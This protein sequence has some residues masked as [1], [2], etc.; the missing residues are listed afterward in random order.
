MSRFVPAGTDADAPD[1]AW[2]KAQQQ[3]ESLRRPKKVDGGTQEGGKS[4]YE[5]LQSNKAAKQEAFEESIRL[6]NQFR[7]LDDDEVEFLDSVLESSRAKENAVK[8]ETA[9]QLEVFRKQRAAAEQALMGGNEAGTPG[10]PAD[11]ESWA[12]KKKKRRRE[13]DNE[14]EVDS[15]LRKVSTT[16]D[17]TTPADADEDQQDAAAEGASPVNKLGIDDEVEPSKAAARPQPAVGLS[18]V[19]YSSDEDE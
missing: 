19:A 18:L 9:E 2:V 12:V 8:Q 17:T 5:V 6:K 10:N 14:S 13:K 15:K 1:D 16:A 4:L 3:V 11:K 7:A